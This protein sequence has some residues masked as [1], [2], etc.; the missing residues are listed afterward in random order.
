M[1]NLAVLVSNGAAGPPDPAGAVRW[2]RAAA[3]Y[4]VR[5]SQYNLG[6]IYARGLG[7]GVD[8]A[9]S[10][11]WFAIAAAGGDKDA[12]ARRDEVAATLDQDKLAIARAAVKA[13][14]PQTPPPP[15]PT[16][17]LVRLAGGAIIPPA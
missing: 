9:E 6:V 15:P 8:V 10:Y 16:R 11:K 3:D 2:F 13:W 7:T 12:S 14:R 1:H 5:D 17:W 4:G